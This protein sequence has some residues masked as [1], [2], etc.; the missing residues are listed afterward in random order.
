MKPS[1]NLSAPLGFR[2]LIHII[3][4][5]AVDEFSRQGSSRLR[6]EPQRLLEQL[7]SVL[8][9]GSRA[10]LLTMRAQLLRD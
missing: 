9:Q 8:G 10:S 1:S 7:L 3:R 2:V 4:V 6:R 5:Q